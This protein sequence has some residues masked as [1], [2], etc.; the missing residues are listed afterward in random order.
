MFTVDKPGFQKMLR[1]FDARYKP[2]GRKYPLAWWKSSA[3]KFP[4]LS[5]LA[6]KYL[7][8]CATS[9][10]S[11]RVFSCSGK[12]VTPLRASMNPQKVDMLT[13]LSKNL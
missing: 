13:F 7:Y 5:K 2:P 9:C 4:L 10:T 1:V 12:I 3:S 6:M 8:V 11:E